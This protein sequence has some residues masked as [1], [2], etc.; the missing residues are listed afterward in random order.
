MKKMLALAALALALSG[1]ALAD[2]RIPSTQVSYKVKK[3]P[4]TGRNAGM[5]FV[6]ALEDR[7]GKTYV[8]FACDDGDAYMRLYSKTILG[9]FVGEQVDFLLRVDDGRLRGGYGR[10]REDTQ[11]NRLAV[12]DV[13]LEQSLDA[14]KLFLAAR[15]KVVIRIERFEMA[16]VTYTFPLKGFVAAIQAIK[17]CD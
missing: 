12:L 7:S 17:Q 9:H 11:T 5:V 8:N 14:L 16:P 6:D 3:D 1:T 13:N 10:L 15:S 2:T 4:L